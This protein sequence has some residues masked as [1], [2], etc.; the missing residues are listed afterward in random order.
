MTADHVVSFSDRGAAAL[1]M[2]IQGMSHISPK[3]GQTVSGVGASC[4]E[5]HAEQQR[6]FLDAGRRR[7]QQR[8]VR[9]HLR[10][11]ADA[12]DRHGRRRSSGYGTS[13]RVPANSATGLTITEIVSP[14][15]T[16]LSS[17]KPTPAATVIGLGGRT[18]PT[19][20]HRGRRERQR[21]DGPGGTSSTRQDG[22]DFYESLEG[23]LLQVNNGVVV[24][25]TQSFGE[26][27]VLADNGAKATGTRTPRGGILPRR[28]PTPTPSG[29]S[30]RRDPPRPDLAAAGEG[31]ARHERRC[32]TSTS[33]VVGPLDYS[34][35]N[36]K[37]QA[38]TTPAFVES[39]IQREDAGSAASRTPGRRRSTSRT[40][41]RA[42]ASKF[43]RARRDDRQQP[44]LA[45]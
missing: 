25:A 45:P 34:F 14:T 20:R 1:I 17:G 6:R 16:V 15:F 21:R 3:N 9:R 26:I 19:R 2:Q 44:A 43:D 12:A 13:R 31:D 35:E 40:S 8:D 11:H 39:P 23:M 42:T 30:R 28:G 18:P 33:P 41:I 36:Y 24:N 4:R 10:L 29:S 22:I 38:M 37:I 27:T 7:R 5:A 32:A